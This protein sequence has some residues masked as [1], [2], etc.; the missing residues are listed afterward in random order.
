MRRYHDGL[1]PTPDASHSYPEVVPDDHIPIKHEKS[2]PEVAPPPPVA[3][4]PAHQQQQQQ[5]Q[6]QQQQQQH[7]HHHHQH[8]HHPLPGG[9]PD[10]SS[11]AAAA[12]AAAVAA[13]AQVPTALPRPSGVHS[14][15]QAWSECDGGEDTQSGEGRVP[16]WKRPIAWVVAMALVIIVVLAG[17]L[18]G[19]A[20]GRIKTAWDSRCADAPG[21]PYLYV[22]RTH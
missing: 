8:Q 10:S 7:H 20:S 21:H 9:S 13:G 15:Q 4:T 16:V 3:T 18:G 1:I 22:F 2:Y 11:S 5:Q 17:I 12:A 19:V 14:L 6:D